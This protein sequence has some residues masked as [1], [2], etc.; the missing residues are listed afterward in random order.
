MKNQKSNVSGSLQAKVLPFTLAALAA[1]ALAS[2]PSAQAQDEGEPPALPSP[3][4]D[5]LQVPAGNQVAFHAYAVGA[6]IYQWNGTA[7]VFVAPAA[8]LYADPG[9]HG[10]VGIH[11]AG[12]T[13]ESNGGS[14]VVGRRLAACTPDT[15]AIPWLLLVAVS[16]HGPGVFDGVTLVQRV[17]TTGGKAPTTPGITVGQRANVPYTAEYYFYK[18]EDSG[19]ED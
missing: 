2:A 7:W 11:F 15:T 17:N 1:L 16:S 9:H 8:V 5:S 19:V 14:Q 18:T 6:Q 12:P 10:Q 4:C 3:L 13:W